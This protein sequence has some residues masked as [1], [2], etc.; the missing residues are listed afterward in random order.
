MGLLDEVKKARDEKKQI[1][2][3]HLVEATIDA[4]KNGSYK[5]VYGFNSDEDYQELIEVMDQLNTELKNDK[6]MLIIKT[7]PA[8]VTCAAYEIKVAGKSIGK[9]N[10]FIQINVDAL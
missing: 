10:S 8:L 3:N 1:K 5:F 2:R 6:I 7:K 4:I 9:F